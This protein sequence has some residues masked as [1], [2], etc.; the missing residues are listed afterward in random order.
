MKK[1]TKK[2]RK[3][4]ST[5]NEMEN[6]DASFLYFVHAMFGSLN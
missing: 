4:G 1:E 3:S 6:A 5:W 2:K